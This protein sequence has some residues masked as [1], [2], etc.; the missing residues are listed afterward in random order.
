MLRLPWA[1]WLV[2]ILQAKT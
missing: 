1:F 2:L